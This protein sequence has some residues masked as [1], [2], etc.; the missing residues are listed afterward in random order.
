M[1]SQ[2]IRTLLPLLVVSLSACAVETAGPALDEEHVESQE[3]P[4]TDGYGPARGHEDLTR[5]GIDAANAKLA[6]VAGTPEFFPTVADGEACPSTTNP[7]LKG[8]CL[9]DFPDE[10]MAENY[11]STADDMAYEPLLQDLHFLRN[12]EGADGA[13]GAREACEGALERIQVATALGVSFW[14]QGDEVRAMRWFGHAT[15]NVQDSFAP[16]H[17]QRSGSHLRVLDDVCV[18]RRTIPGVCTH[19]LISTGDRI[20]KDS[21]SCWMNPFARPFRCLKPEAQEA[22]TATAGYLRVV[23][24]YLAQGAQGDLHANL[25]SWF[26][27]VTS[28]GDSGYFRCSL[29]P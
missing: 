6:S 25:Q 11:D 24:T 21:W 20:W 16:A 9:T 12:Y 7:L 19:P 10:E 5:F 28:E 3:Q 4:W 22:S 13:V 17:T 27:T 8:N 14:L 15:H 1:S 23:G 29:L 2:S 26:E 18:Y